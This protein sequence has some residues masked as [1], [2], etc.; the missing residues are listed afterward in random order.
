MIHDFEEAYTNCNKFSGVIY[1]KLFAE[2]KESL[3][4][5]GK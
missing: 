2:T 3:S 4:V 5:E 1:N